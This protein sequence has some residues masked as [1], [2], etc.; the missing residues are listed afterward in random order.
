LKAVS[1]REAKAT[2]EMAAAHVFEENKIC[3]SLTDR[4]A[5]HRVCYR[6]NQSRL[7]GNI[8][9]VMD[10]LLSRGQPIA[11]ALP[12]IESRRTEAPEPPCALPA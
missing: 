4:R 11:A 12:M 1:I 8:Q 7:W 9:G 6:V 10:F 3:S 5:V 2:A